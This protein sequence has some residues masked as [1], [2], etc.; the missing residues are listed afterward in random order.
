MLN[1]LAVLFS[2]ESLQALTTANVGETC[3]STFPGPGAVS[4]HHVR[5]HPR[6]RAPHG[7]RTT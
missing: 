4:D 2:K 7:S 6:P 1:F 5:A 3:V